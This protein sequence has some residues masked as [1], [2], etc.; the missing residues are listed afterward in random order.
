M[1]GDFFLEIFSNKIEESVGDGNTSTMMPFRLKCACKFK[2]MCRE[3][4]HKMHALPNC[5][6]GEWGP[7]KARRHFKLFPVSHE[8]VSSALT[9]LGF[10][11]YFGC[12]A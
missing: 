7:A 6:T 4:K 9:I 10:M 8:T 1:K 12:I 11:L 3:L 5:A 2:I